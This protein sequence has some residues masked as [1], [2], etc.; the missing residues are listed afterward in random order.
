MCKARRDW[1]MRDHVAE[2]VQLI[3]QQ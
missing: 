1:V 3:R 2:A